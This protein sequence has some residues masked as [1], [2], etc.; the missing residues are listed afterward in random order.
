MTAQ[1]HKADTPEMFTEIAPRYDLLNHMLSFNIDRL[2]RRKLVAMAG[3][4]ERGRAL[5]VCTGTGDVAIGFARRYPVADIVGLD[6]SRGMLEVGRDK[7]EKLHLTDRVH[8][9]EGDALALPFADG[10]FDAVTIAFGLRNLPDYAAGVGEM[11]RVLKPGG[12][13]LVL[14]FSPPSH[15][16]YLRG[17]EFYLRNV[18]PL[19]GGLV[20]GSRRAYRYLAS[21]IGDFFPR[22]DALALM[23]RTGFD[24]VDAVRLAGGVAY[25]YHGVKRTKA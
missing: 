13:L 3:L 10:S 12:R 25:I 9:Q 4:P 11:A 20:S 16:I 14:E 7:L 8:L 5:D 2:W 18:L 17:Y 23:Q 21:S 19:I 15:G 24:A 1:V 6:R 22:D